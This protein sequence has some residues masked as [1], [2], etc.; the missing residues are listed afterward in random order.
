LPA[1]PGTNSNNLKPLTEEEKMTET[2][3]KYV[4]RLSAEDGDKVRAALQKLGAD[5]QQAMA[6]LE[7]STA[8]ADAG[9]SILTRSVM[10]RLIPAISAAALGNAVRG[11]VR[12][13][14]DLADAA[15][16][17][18]VSAEKLQV[19]RLLGQDVGA[20]AAAADEGLQEFSKRVGQAAAGTGKLRD[21]LLDY[22]IALVD[23]TGRAR[24]AL[25]IMG[26]LADVI[27]GTADG[28]ERLRIA[29]AMGMEDFVDGLRGGAEGLQHLEDKA[30]ETGL[31]IDQELIDRAEEADKK[32]T[33]A[34]MHFDIAWK[35]A[36]GG[37]ILGFIELNKQAEQFNR[38]QAIRFGADPMTG[39]AIKPGSLKARAGEQFG[40]PKPSE[41]FGP[42]APLP[43]G[44]GPGMHK[45][46]E[47]AVKLL[48][49]ETEK[50]E[51]V[52]E[53]LQ[54]RNEQV[55]RN[56]R[57]QDLYNQLRQAGVTISSEEG[58]QIARL[59]NEFHDLAAAQD[60]NKTAAQALKS[61]V[62]DVITNFDDLRSVGLRALSDLLQG[63][64]DLSMGQQASSSV[65]GFLATSIFGAFGSA[66]L[67][68]RAL[69]AAGGPSMIGVKPPIPSF[70]VG[71]PYVPRDMVAEIHRG[72]RIMTAAENAA[73]SRG[74]NAP[75]YSIT[76]H[77]NNSTDPAETNRQVRDAVDEALRAKVPGIV[78][79]SAAHA[80]ASIEDKN[81]R[82]TGYL[83]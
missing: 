41:V 34:A 5:S 58:Q 36:L 19:F 7:N 45:V 2:R 49:Q 15:E 31:M 64:I 51:R 71:T 83:K 54:F 33:E 55:I 46:H 48:E 8:K 73:Y 6:V 25:E 40:P 43:A 52:T 47:E 17:A 10:T 81:R 30:R 53:A 42:P 12:E 29:S 44:V 78:K 62:D 56:A 75:T 65:G 21:V 1:P 26:D 74:T 27:Q 80:Q 50:I 35:N 61:A 66:S 4:I 28:S 22:K 9:L 60:L 14:A 39:E 24:P 77:V 79:A 59:V 23:S 20:G 13:L 16:R 67:G 18:G 68:S 82:R 11:T 69:A 57:E 72:E 37:T 38:F 63:F 76:V 70:D 32:W 3:H